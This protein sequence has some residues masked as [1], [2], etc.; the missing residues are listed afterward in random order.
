MR[1]RQILYDEEGD[2]LYLK[3]SDK[4]A[5]GSVTIV[6]D[7]ILLRFNRRDR[8]AVGLTFIAFSHLLPSVGDS[9]PPFTLERLSA[10]PDHLRQLVWDII[11]RPPVTEYLRVLP[12]PTEAESR[13]ALILQPALTGLLVAA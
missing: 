4:P 13:I 2:I 5:E 11:N 9:A 10:L 8:E 12:G 1:K 6:E 7:V 3:F